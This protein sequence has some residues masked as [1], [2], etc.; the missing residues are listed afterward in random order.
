MQVK[1]LGTNVLLR[2]EEAEETT[3]SGIILT[4]SAKEAPS[5]ATVVACGPGTAEEKMEV[6]PGDKVIFAKYT[7]TSIKLEGTE[8]TM[9]F[10]KDILAVVE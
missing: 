3:Q 7:G 4:G 2:K 6:K 10:Q 5:W 9:V 1:P 8:Y